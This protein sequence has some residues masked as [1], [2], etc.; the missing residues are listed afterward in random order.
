MLS[1]L[2]A[3]TLHKEAVWDLESQHRGGG[4]R[5]IHGRSSQR[6]SEFEVTLGCMR[7]CFQKKEIILYLKKKVCF[8][9]GMVVYTMTIESKL[10]G[11]TL[12]DCECA[13]TRGSRTKDSTQ[14]AGVRNQSLVWFL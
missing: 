10:T 9:L 3:P 8:K 2:K 1:M 11:S 13:C 14:H 4:G 6:Y 5:R 7:P 12:A